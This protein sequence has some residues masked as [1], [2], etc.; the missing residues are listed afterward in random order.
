MRLLIWWFVKGVIVVTR[1]RS[2]VD[3]LQ[4]RALIL[5]KRRQVLAIG[6]PLKEALT[7]L[8]LANGR[9]RR[10]VQ[11]VTSARLAEIESKLAE[12]TQPPPPGL[13]VVASRIEGRRPFLRRGDFAQ[14]ATCRLPPPLA[15][16]RGVLVRTSCRLMSSSASEPESFSGVPERRGKRRPI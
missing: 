6:F 13:Q 1:G 10:V 14:A 8:N 15:A 3:P 16:Q 11:I 4:V 9:K 5:V 7:G 12:L 2:T